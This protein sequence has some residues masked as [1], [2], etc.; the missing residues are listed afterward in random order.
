ME[1]YAEHVQAK[2]T[3]LYTLKV[4]VSYIL[5]N[6]DKCSKINYKSIKILRSIVI[7]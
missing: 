1:V 2:A 4:Y 7:S 3:S 5:Y 6:R